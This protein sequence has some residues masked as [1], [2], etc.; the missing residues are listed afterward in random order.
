MGASLHPVRLEAQIGELVAQHDD[1]ALAA[2][3]AGLGEF[4]GVGARDLQLAF[5]VARKA[6]AR[7]S[8]RVVEELDAVALA[9]RASR[10]QRALA[11]PHAV[12]PQQCPCGEEDDRDRFPHPAIVP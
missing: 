10:L 1:R 4:E 9:C 3:V 2:V 6:Q 7:E 11:H 5:L 8:H 12:E